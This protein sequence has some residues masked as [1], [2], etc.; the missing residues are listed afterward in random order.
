[1]QLVV[2]VCT[3]VCSNCHDLQPAV[4]FS[5]MYCRFFPLLHSYPVCTII[6]SKRLRITKMLITGRRY[7]HDLLQMRTPLSRAT[8]LAQNTFQ[9]TNNNDEHKS[10]TDKHTRVTHPNIILFRAQQLR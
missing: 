8:I 3:S 1:M 9:H 2:E 4:A 5:L 7:Y 6:S 10:S